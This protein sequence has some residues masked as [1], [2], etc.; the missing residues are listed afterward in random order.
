MQKQTAPTGFGASVITPQQLYDNFLTDRGFIDIDQAELGL[1]LLSPEET[2]ELIGHTKEWTVKIPYRDVQGQDTGFNRVRLLQPK[3]KM[4]YSQARASGSHIYFPPKTNWP[5]VLMDVDV[6]IIITEG[7]FKAW[8]ITKEIVKGSLPYACLGLAGVTSWTDKNGLHLH[9]DLM[10]IM[11]KKK[12][13]FESKSRKV[14]VIFDYD[15]AKDDGELNEQVALAE[16]KLAITLRGMGAEVH[17]CRVGKFSRGPGAKYAIDDHLQAGGNLGDVMTSISIVM[18]GVDTL[19]VKLHE[20]STKYALFNG[21]V[22]RLG[23]GLIMSFQKAKIDSAQHIFVQTNTVQG[24]AGQPPKVVTKEVAMLEEYKKWH[25]RCDIRKVGVFPQ[26]QG[27]RVTPDGCYNYLN[28]WAYEPLAGSIDLYTKFCDYFFRDEPEFAD[29]WHNWVANIIQFPHRRNNTTPQFV[30]N[31]EGI[32]KSA[33]AEFIAE[34]MGIGE[35]GAA[36]IVGPDELFG[37]FNGI[38]KNKIFV[39]VNEPSS[40]REDHSAKLKNFITSKEI[41][42][43]NKYGHQYS[44][45]NFMNFVFTTNRPYVTT[46]GNNARREAIYKPETLTNKETRPMV[47]ELMKWARTGGFSHV[48]NWYYER[49]IANFDPFEAAPNTKRKA[50]IV[51]LSQSPTQQFANDLI[52]WTKSNIGEAAFFTNQQLQILFKTWQGEEKIPATKYIKAALAN[53]HPGDEVIVT[54]KKDPTDSYKTITVRGWMVGLQNVIN[55]CNKRQ[56][57]EKTADA[58]AREVQNSNESF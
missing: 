10:Q 55:T 28:S 30:S 2:K 54:L 18:N 34:M 11:W 46:M 41:T 8:A 56:V 19:D 27:L 31:I 58:I 6:P 42:I 36:C 16:T 35:G 53:L 12:T 25:K 48:L 51:K 21:D 3:T 43:N 37:S 14:Y 26:Y 33:V 38:L 22:I 13:S 15:G 39:V 49:D 44:I 47:N 4:K 45:E 9:K 32:G 40:D 29:Y 1:E 5:R 57:A 23:D 52:E 50:Q 24:R 20:F 17:L 7:E